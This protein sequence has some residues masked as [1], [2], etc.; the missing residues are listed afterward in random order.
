MKYQANSTMHIA[1]RKGM[2][3]FF[4][5]QPVGSLSVD[6][7]YDMGSF[8]TGTENRLKSE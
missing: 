2:V 4:Y 8:A 1:P 3:F 7:F 6:Q 5:H